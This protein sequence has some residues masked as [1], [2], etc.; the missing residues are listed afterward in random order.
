M[1]KIFADLCFDLADVFTR[2]A[3]EFQSLA[4]GADTEPEKETPAP[5]KTAKKASKKVA[6]K[7]TK[8]VAEKK[9]EQPDLIFG[10]QEPE[11]ADE[12]RFKT[13][14]ELTKAVQKANANGDVSMD[15]LQSALLDM[16]YKM[17]PEIPVERLDEYANAVGI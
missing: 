3:A 10:D 7:A 11:T 14:E 17:I 16:G 15:A 13:A 8:K 1:E 4:E 12:P 2:A 5:K 6:K 9:E